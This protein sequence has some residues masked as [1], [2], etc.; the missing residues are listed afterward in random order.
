MVLIFGSGSYKTQFCDHGGCHSRNQATTSLNSLVDFPQISLLFL[1]A[2][3]IGSVVILHLLSEEG[4][5]VLQGSSV[6]RLLLSAVPV[7]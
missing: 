5:T 6:Y 4:T 2:T 1:V 3:P 7:V